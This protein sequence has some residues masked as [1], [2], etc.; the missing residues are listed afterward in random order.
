[1]SMLLP[2]PVLLPLVTAIALFLVRRHQKIQERLS[3][4]SL[5]V[6]LAF[7]LSLLTATAGG[8]IFI[9]RMGM[10]PFP[11]GI[12]LAA[13]RLTGTMVVLAAAIV[14]ACTLFAQ[15]YLSTNQRREVFHPLIHFQLM[16][17]QG[18]FMT[19]DLFNLFVF[20][21]VMLISTYA[22]LAFYYNLDQL[23]VALKYTFLNLVASAMFLV[24]ISFLYAQV[25]TVNMADLSVKIRELGP[26]P[27]M[28]VTAFVFLFVFSMKAALF[29]M[30]LWLPSAHS[31]SPTHIGAVLAGVLVKVGI[32]SIIRCATL[33]F[34][35]PFEKLQT[36]L[37]VIALVTI[38]WGAL[39]TLPQRSL[40][41]ILAYSTIN[42]LGYIA[43]GVALLS[44]LGMT[45]AIFYI[46]SHAF[47]KSSMLLG[48][49]LNQKL[50]GTVDLDEMGGMMAKAPYASALMLVGFLSLAGI[51]PLSGFFSKLFLLQAGFTQG[52][53]LATGLALLMG[54][55]SLYYNFTTYQRMAWGTGGNEAREAPATMYSS[56]SFLASFAVIF[57]IGAAWLYEW[58]HLVASQITR[59]ELYI[60]A[61]RNAL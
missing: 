17:I 38:V 21:E 10:W 28:V 4:A 32:Y 50:T 44:P 6:N 47:L 34:I 9:H 2:V 61:M 46:V 45:A 11:F 27:L 56:V 13:D 16:G 8:E 40:K 14:A 31:I 41:R 3:N 22:L 57:G 55:I 39:G 48:A 33:I 60:S 18:A 5:A 35:G 36:V 58:S 12:I 51:P 42:Q 19:G 29:P 15:G 24:G 52:A 53:Y 25:G 20:F 7:A 59:P 23:E 26:Q 37:M 49:G 1:M 43:F 54:V 30:H